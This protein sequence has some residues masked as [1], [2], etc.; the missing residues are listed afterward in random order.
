MLQSNFSDLMDIN[1]RAVLIVFLGMI[2][3]CG[4]ARLYDK[5][6]QPFWHALVPGLN[7]VALMRIIGRPDLHALW[8]LVP[9]ANL[10]FVARWLVELAQSFGKTSWVDYVMVVL[11]NAFY[12]LNLGLAYSEEY[13]G[14]VYEKKAEAA[15]A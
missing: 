12:V 7:V 3:A 8:I 2:A 6:G 15:F 13:E 9:G 14:P 5:A 11:F 1:Q 4:A 10:Y